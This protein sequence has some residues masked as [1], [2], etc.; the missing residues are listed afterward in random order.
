[1]T[2]QEITPAELMHRIEHLPR[3]TPRHKAMEQ[4][5]QNGAGFGR[6]WYGSQK[7]HWQTWLA[8]YSGPGAYGRAARGERP[9]RYVYNHIHCAPMLF[10][11]A[12]AAGVADDLLEGSYRAVL[13]ERASDG[14][15]QCAAPRLVIPWE[16]MPAALEG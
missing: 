2:E 11:L 14:G 1:M 3:D 5:L 6:A 12:E 13:Q 7:E 9:A 4:A 16:A 15:T 10:W 8:E